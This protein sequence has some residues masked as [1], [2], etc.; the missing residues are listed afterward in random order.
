MLQHIDHSASCYA[1]PS[2]Q[3]DKN[4]VATR[5]PAAPPVSA[6]I[7]TTA[8]IALDSCMLS[9][10][11]F[12]SLMPIIDN[13]GEIHPLLEYIIIVISFTIFSNI[14]IGFYTSYRNLLRFKYTI[15]TI[16]ILISTFSLLITIL[17][18]AR[19]QATLGV[20]WLFLFVFLS[21]VLLIGGRLILVAVLTSDP[22]RR[23]APRAVIVGVAADGH[24]S[25]DALR[26]CS[27][28]D[29]R[30]LGYVADSKP[31]NSCMTAH[32]PY[33]GSTQELF[34]IIRYDAVDEVIITPSS[35]DA[36]QI[37]QLLRL[38]ADYPVHVRLIL[39]L[40]GS[41]LSSR[42]PVF[43]NVPSFLSM[44][45]RPISGWSAAL[46]RA[47]DLILA[48]FM[49]L[50]SLPLLAT[51]SLAIYIDDR[52]P[53]IF[54]QRR[55]GF[56]NR[57][58]ELLKFRSMHKGRLEPVIS[59]QAVRNDPRVTRVGGTLR[60]LSLDELPQLI[61]VLRGEMSIVGPR[62]H[63][64]GTRAGGRLFEDI[65]N[66]YAARHRV[67][68]GITGLAQVRG[69]R[70][71]TETEDKLIRRVN[72]DLEYIERWSLWLDLVIIVRTVFGV[73]RMKNAW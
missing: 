45:E 33:L 40:S 48:S 14:I 21:S 42:R 60:R 12:L 24:H 35:L 47:E 22:Q 62:P 2:I 58:F 20:Y 23:F 70:G 8:A 64:P 43:L 19:S 67:K 4:T 39:P 11:A 7:I 29:L 5:V 56:N 30:L 49:L 34:R 6:S 63:A 16:T 69:Y 15:F 66:R 3:S 10:A 51:I 52:G 57:N 59:R 25:L 28:R 55:I 61:N 68:P 9:I 27:Q 18:S 1:A 44:S 65:V 17:P 38:L 36:P 32:I 53:I 72:S 41:P 73:L 13:H 54:R 26:R 46:K 37:N 31:S 50:V 71:E